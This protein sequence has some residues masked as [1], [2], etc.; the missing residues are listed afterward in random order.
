M[1][2]KWYDE[3]RPSVVV[4][5]ELAKKNGIIDGDFYLA[6]LLSE[7]NMTLKEKLFVLLKSDHYELDR[8]IDDM[9]M[10]SSRT[11]TFHDGMKAHNKFWA[12]YERPP[13][14]EYWEYIVNR[15]DLLV[16]QDVR[17]R[18]G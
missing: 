9:G 1:F 5:W 7:G 6:D 17:V 3:V 13:K 2:G 12:K 14:S 8:K 18:K 15:R 11:A 4:N 16:P 10:F